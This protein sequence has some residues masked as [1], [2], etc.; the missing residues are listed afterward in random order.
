MMTFDVAPL[1]LRW[2]LERGP[3]TPLY[4]LTYDLLFAYPGLGPLLRRLGC[5]PASHVNGQRA[6]DKGAS[7]VVFPGGD[8]EVF[9]HWNER[10]RIRF[11]G[12]MG[13]IE[14]ALHAGV[15]VVP[16]TIHG[17]HESTLV[18][19]RGRHL[20]SRVGLTRL[21]IKVFPV[22]WNIPFGITPAFVPSFPLP[23]KVTVC[24]GE[25]IDW[26]HIDPEQAEDPAIL[27]A[28]YDEVTGAMQATLDEL[29]HE[30]PH[31]LLARVAEY[32]H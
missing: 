1:M 4:G 18:L 2:I 12:H 30:R 15:R 23:A 29:A 21:R 14:L 25:P 3:A 28:C 6:L 31:P 8:F 24:L 13:F 22:I 5:L 32:L 17:A 7:V 20:A 27:Q 26:R 11:G 9:R 10:N 16:M 19:T